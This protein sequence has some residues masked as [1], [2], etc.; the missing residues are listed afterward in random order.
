[1]TLFKTSVLGALDFG[2]RAIGILVLMK[3]AAIYAGPEGVGYFGQFQNL[4]AIAILLSGGIFT[5]VLIR[6][7]AENQEDKAYLS[8]FWGS[9]IALSLGLAIISAFS[10]IVLSQTSLYELIA[11]GIKTP[12]FIV[13]SL[14]LIPACLQ[15]F[16]FAVSNGLE[17]PKLLFSI[18]ITS[19]VI[20][21]S[22]FAALLFFFEFEWALL[23]LTLAPALTMILCFFIFRK[24]KIFSLGDLSFSHI[25]THFKI[26]T[27]YGLMSAI[28]ALALPVVLLFTRSTLLTKFGGEE[29]GNWEGAFRIGD[30]YLV[31]ISS[32][33][34]I[35]YLPK[36]AKQKDDLSKIVKEALL[37]SFTLASIGGVL[38][39]LLREPIVG[40]LLDQSFTLTTELLGVQI[41]AS[42]VKICAWVFAFIMVT[43]A[44][45][46]LF[47][48][49]EVG[50]S[51]LLLSLVYLAANVS[52]YWV[53]YAFLITYPIYF[54][55]CLVVYLTTRLNVR[56]A[57]L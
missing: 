6:F 28:S 45:H 13:S 46:K 20:L 34:T 55:Y 10:L 27:Q 43:R 40:L 15:S 32:I 52:I 39:Y 57:D 4:F 22:V 56:T 47:I 54:V 33:L 38:I 51:L 49:G 14:L 53:N 44:Q 19:V 37:F 17:N 26:Y 5:S 2:V 42:I 24:L 9:A 7:T 41:A 8:K 35:Y 1:M 11:P 16:F 18:R 50:A 12:I 31:F 23:A 36:F 25:R 30:Q 21:V 48:I 3:L 29:L